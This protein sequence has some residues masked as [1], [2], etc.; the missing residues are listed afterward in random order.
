MKQAPP[1][2]L[3]KKPRRS[4]QSGLGAQTRDREED[5]DERVK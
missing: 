1:Y 3:K 4:G 2:V 5:E